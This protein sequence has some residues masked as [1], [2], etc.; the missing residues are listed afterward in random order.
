MQCVCLKEVCRK[1]QPDGKNFAWES[2]GDKW[3]LCCP[4]CHSRRW[5]V[6]DVPNK[7]V[8]HD[9]NNGGEGE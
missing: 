8:V 7:V 3:P 5:S 4:D 1:R 2:R 6:P 9:N